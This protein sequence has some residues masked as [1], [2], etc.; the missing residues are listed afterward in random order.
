MIEDDPLY[1]QGFSHVGDA[2]A[3]QI[4]IITAPPVEQVERRSIAAEQLIE[5]FGDLVFG[6]T[7]AIDG[8]VLRHLDTDKAEQRP[9]VGFFKHHHPDRVMVAVQMVRQLT[10]KCGLAHA[11]AGSERDHLAFSQTSSDF[12]QQRI[13]VLN[14]GCFLVWGQR[15]DSLWV[16]MPSGLKSRAW[17]T[18]R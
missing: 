9:L 1:A 11:G 12:I 15:P 7:G 18:P 10:Y 6:Y 8:D 2:I 14:A 4:N 17:K 5:G 3:D 16:T 13:R